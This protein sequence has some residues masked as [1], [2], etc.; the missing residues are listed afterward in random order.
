MNISGVFYS[1]QT[2]KGERRGRTE[3]GAKAFPEFGV[4]RFPEV[5]ESFDIAGKPCQGV[6]DLDFLK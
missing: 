2:E 3:T 5:G 4:G 1:A 6:T